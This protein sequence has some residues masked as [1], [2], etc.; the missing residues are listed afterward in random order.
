MTLFLMSFRNFFGI[1][2]VCLTLVIKCLHVK[3]VLK[4][5]R[6]QY[7]ARIPVFCTDLTM[8]GSCSSD[9]RD[10]LPLVVAHEWP[11]L[12]PPRPALLCPRLP[13]GHT[14][15]GGVATLQQYFDIHTQYIHIFEILLETSYINSTDLLFLCIEDEGGAVC[16]S[17]SVASALGPGLGKVRCYCCLPRTRGDRGR[18]LIKIRV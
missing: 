15:A 16:V 6:S 12:A 5:H 8:T 11:H 7:S 13:G 14:L 18:I 9:P 17:A 1:F 10:L 3:M 2:L 4:I